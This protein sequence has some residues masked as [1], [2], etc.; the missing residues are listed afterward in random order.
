MIP[1]STFEPLLQLMLMGGLL[2]LAF[3]AWQWFQLRHEAR[4]Q[5]ERQLCEDMEKA[6][7]EEIWRSGQ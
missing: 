1:N 4:V 7:E 6:L 3:R 2:V 5:R